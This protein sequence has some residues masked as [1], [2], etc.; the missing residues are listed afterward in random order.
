[1]KIIGS[2]LIGGIISLY[3][4]IPSGIGKT[5]NPASDITFIAST[6]GD[7]LIKSMLA[8][9]NNVKV[10]FIRW[11]LALK[12]SGNA[13]GIFFLDISYGESKPN[14]LGF[15]DERKMVLKGKYTVKKNLNK[16]IH[17]LQGDRHGV[18]LMLSKINDNLFHILTPDSKLMIGNG[19]WSYTLNRKDPLGNVSAAAFRLDDTSKILNDTSRQL[20]FEGRSPCK[21]FAEQYGLDVNS[22]CIKLKWGLVL[23]KDPI[24]LLPTTYKLRK[25]LR[26]PADTEGKWR[27]LKGIKNNPDAI[28]YQLDPDI[29]E[30]SFSFLAGDENIL[31]FLDR[32]ES[33]YVGD[34]NFSYTL[35]RRASPFISPGK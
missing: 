34:S 35:N 8:I 16:D 14:T 7:S 13:S 17:H 27:I 22:P 4:V 19:G 30:K 3:T 33:L 15:I 23:Y 10:D 5:P 29:P 6:P 11:D 1:M 24:T 25:I 21:E 20:V 12:E 26:Q 2:L 18:S 9:P 31:F 28:I 32:N